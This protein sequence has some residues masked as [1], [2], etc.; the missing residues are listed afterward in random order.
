MVREDMVKPRSEVG[1]G[2]QV[3]VKEGMAE[4]GGKVGEGSL[5]K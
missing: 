3:Q 1:E 5:L 2:I 4:A